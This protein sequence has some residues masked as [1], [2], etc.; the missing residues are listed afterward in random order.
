MDRKQF[1]KSLGLGAAALVVVNEI[2]S[3]KKDGTNV[4][5]SV[6]MSTPQFSALLT[7][8][9]SAVSNQIIIANTSS[10]YV[11]VSDVCTHAG[12]GVNFSSSANQFQ[13]PCHGAR[14]STSGAVLNGPATS[15]LKKYTVT[16]SGNTLHITS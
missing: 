16:Q 3:C 15:A 12:C 8:G 1:L 6:D 11:A 13:C 14:F 7:V 10:G 9:G 4:D 5:F 2:Q